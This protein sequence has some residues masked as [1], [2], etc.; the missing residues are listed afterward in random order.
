MSARQDKDSPWKYVTTS[1]SLFGTDRFITI[2][3]GAWLHEI[4]YGD[5]SNEATSN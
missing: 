2:S 1:Q 4:T 3:I 5:D